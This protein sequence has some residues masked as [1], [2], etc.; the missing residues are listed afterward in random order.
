[1]PLLTDVIEEHLVAERIAIDGY[2][3]IVQWVAPFEPVT[4][5]CTGAAWAAPGV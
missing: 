1:M 4:R 5:A 3:E 2:R